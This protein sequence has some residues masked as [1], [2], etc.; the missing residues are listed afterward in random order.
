MADEKKLI[1]D[2]SALV[3]SGGEVVK[4][5]KG[6]DIHYVVVY[7]R[8]KRIWFKGGYRNK[9]ESVGYF[10]LVEFD[11]QGGGHMYQVSGHH[12][13]GPSGEGQDLLLQADSLEE[14]ESRGC[15]LGT[16]EGDLAAWVV[17]SYVEVGARQYQVEIP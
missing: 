11:Y 12:H 10:N 9:A 7:G 1:E 14:L 2:V 8:P 3:S 13:E 15:L 16:R 5:Y 17:R 6:R 4:A